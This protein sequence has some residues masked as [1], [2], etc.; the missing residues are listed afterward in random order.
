MNMFGVPKYTVNSR[1][2]WQVIGERK[3]WRGLLYPLTQ[4]IAVT[5]LRP[6]ISGVN[7][8]TLGSP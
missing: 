3:G 1:S 5:T 4:N 7:P 6:G 2:K 8:E